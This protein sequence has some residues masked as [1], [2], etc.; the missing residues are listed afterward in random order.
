MTNLPPSSSKENR[1]FKNGQW[2]GMVTGLLILS[3]AAYFY[4]RNFVDNQLS[5]LISKELGKILDRP[6]HLGQLKAISL[7]HLEFATSQILPTKNDP[8]QITIAKVIVKFNPWQ[9]ITQRLIVLNIE[10]FNPDIYLEQS[11]RGDWLLTPLKIPA[12]GKDNLIKLEFKKL[13]IEQGRVTLR[14]RNLHKLLNPPLRI[15]I[16]NGQLE[17]KIDKS[18]LIEYQ[19]AGAIGKG[20]LQAKGTTDLNNYLTKVKL[21]SGQLP[22]QEVTKLLP[23]SLPLA[24]GHLGTQLQVDFQ[25]NRPLKLAGKAQFSQVMIK[26]PQL[27]EPISKVQGSVKF[28]DSKIIVDDGITAEFG[29]TKSRIRGI[30]DLV[31]G[32]QLSLLTEPFSFSDIL[33]TLKIKTLSIKLKGSAQARVKVTGELN[34]PQL[35]L[36]LYSTKSDTQI[37]KITLNQFKI[38]GK[39]SGSDLAL[40]DWQAS[41]LVGGQLSG[42]GQATIFSEKRPSVFTLNFKAKDIPADILAKTYALALPAKLGTVNMFGQI[43]GKLV[44]PNQIRLSGHAQGNLLGG[45]INLNNVEYYN[46]YNSWKA[47]LKVENIEPDISG[48][49]SSKVGTYLNMKGTLDH[50][51]VRSLKIKGNAQVLVSQGKIDI[52]S[53]TVQDG[54]WNA[55]LRTDRLQIPLP[56]LPVKSSLNANIWADGSLAKMQETLKAK[57]NAELF[58]NQGKII[59]DQLAIKAGNWNAQVQANNLDISPFVAKVPGKINAN[60]AMTGLLRDPIKNIQAKGS[61][62]VSSRQGQIA[63]SQINL[64]NEQWQTKAQLK[65][66]KLA[67]ISPQLKGKL[68]GVISLQGNLSKL[69]LDNIKAQGDLHF[70]QG[71]SLI[72]QPLDTR[73]NWQG[74]RLELLKVSAK[75]IRLKGY[76]DIDTQKLNQGISGLADFYVEVAARNL[77]LEK[78]PLPNS[79]AK[80]KSQGYLDFSGE[81]KGNPKSPQVRGNLALKKFSFGPIIVEPIL[82]GTIV[83]NRSIGSNLKLIG[84]KDRIIAHLDPNFKL[85]NIDLELESVKLSAST[86][87]NYVDLTVKSLS[88][89][90]LKE[91]LQYSAL[92]VNAQMLALSGNF[93]GDFKLDL[94]KKELL[95]N[96]LQITNPVLGPIRGDL[97]SGDLSFLSGNLALKKGSFKIKN[98]QY[99]IDG[100][101]KI[102]GDFDFQV[103]TKTKDADIQSTLEALDI[104]EFGD[105]AHIFS[106]PVYTKARGLYTEKQIEQG[107]IFDIGKSDASVTYQLRRYSEIKTLFNL[108][109][110][111]DKQKFT[112]PELRKLKGNFDAELSL[113]GSLKQAINAQF[114]FIGQRWQWDKLSIE[115][116]LAKGE[117]HNGNAIEL[118]P[119]KIRSGDSVVSLSGNIDNYQQTGELELIKIPLSLI[120]EFFGLP[121]NLNFA[122]MLNADLLLEGNRSNPQAKGTIDIVDGTV[123]K[124]PLKSAQAQFIYRDSVLSFSA[125]SILSN[126]TPPVTLE[127]KFPY[128]LPFAKK[129]PLNDD[130]AFNVNL[131][132]GGLMLLNI[133]TREEWRW[134]SGRGIVDLSV[135]G[136][137]DHRQNKLAAVKVDGSIELTNGAL[138]AQFIPD[139]PIT[140]INGKIY[141]DFDRINI[142]E[143][144]AKFSGSQIKVSGDLPLTKSS[145]SVSKNLSIDFGGLAFNLKGL[146]KG[147]LRGQLTF[148]GTA[149]NPHIGGNIELSNGQILLG[150]LIGETI[151]P[152]YSSESGKMATP[153]IEFDNLELTLKDGVQLNQFPVLSFDTNGSLFLNGTLDQPHPEG[154]IKLKGGLVN[155]FTTQFRLGGGEEN[156]ATFSP[157]H[158]LDPYLKIR[159]YSSAAETQRNLI[160][161]DN[162]SSEINNPFTANIDSLQTVRIEAKVDGYASDLEHNIELTSV[163]ARSQTEIITLLGGGGDPTIGLANLASSAILGS[164]QETLRSSLGFSQFRVFPTQLINPQDRIGTA[165]MGIAAEVG[166]DISP[167]IFFSAQQ[168][169]NIQRP[170]QFGLRYSINDNLYIRGSS[171]FSDDSRAVV[172]YE[173]RF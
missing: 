87:N 62:Q 37:D 98:A 59:V 161:T 152:N 103:N 147:G 139:Q 88:L 132:D 143:L 136:S 121:P 70:S 81:L 146:Y 2:I 67:A 131:Q 42:N 113:S 32:Y 21:I 69:T 25:P 111:K 31:R 40:Q 3:G 72:D 1:T 120:D 13:L 76:L 151:Q 34:K 85:K 118:K 30:L 108:E 29:N 97:F 144:N 50:N 133:L 82:T 163:P 95:G 141:L 153:V 127:G 24:G 102:G 35:A 156:T 170:T 112:L 124:T 96:H 128:Q 142:R 148:T 41:P 159:L 119:V 86:Y 7:N 154:T 137:F 129:A 134:L 12:A 100:L 53:I 55:N 166:V 172:Q 135:Y 36:Y 126:G 44:D 104:F 56:G 66:I 63:L 28:I 47:Q 109:Q 145:L 38:R 49:P 51:A 78:L 45:T 68:R 105:F 23:V 150:S 10:A 58:F 173:F 140:G 107:P 155:L 27:P 60:L 75:D 157:S 74:K 46:R 26:L 77:N 4:G 168:I 164:F 158:G 9:A 39:L 43:K 90:W 65:D 92:P 130:F 15:N 167:S 18:S 71:I 5:P 57:G 138:A 22:V 6:V 84:K 73:F 14:A 83:A 89:S 165:Q 64:K 17:L 79:L 94:E 54:Y 122:G 52:P 61:A 169:L 101:L 110:E 115:E 160:R 123:N 33:R 114:S 91:F 125:N 11:V 117:L 80:I 99:Q 93:F 19:L 162:L 48:L 16:K 20:N 116:I 149:L 171:N 106:S 8:D